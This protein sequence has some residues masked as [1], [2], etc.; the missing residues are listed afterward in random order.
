MERCDAHFL[1][2][3]NNVPP[4]QYNTWLTYQ[5]ERFWIMA[6]E[7]WHPQSVKSDNY[8]IYLFVTVIGLILHQKSTWH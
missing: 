5:R 2:A 4:L 8:N 6:T 1:L 7:W 3:Y